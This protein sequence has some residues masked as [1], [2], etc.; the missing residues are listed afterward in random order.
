MVN[1]SLGKIYKIVS[2][3]TDK[4]YIGSTCLEKLCMRLSKHK[5]TIEFLSP[6]SFTK[7]FIS[8]RENCID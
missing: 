2:D 3:L 4:I 7:E 8:L 1:Y 6:N 5:Y